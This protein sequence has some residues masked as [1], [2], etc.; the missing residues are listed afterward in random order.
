[1][2]MRIEAISC[3]A[4]DPT[5]WVS[6]GPGLVAEAGECLMPPGGGQSL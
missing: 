3:L 1:M 4:S 6:T 5:L 2:W